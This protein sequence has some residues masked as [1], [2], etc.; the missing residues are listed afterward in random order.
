MV[1]V[2]T[3]RARNITRAIP[4]HEAKAAFMLNK[5]L[6]ALPNGESRGAGFRLF[7]QRVQSAGCGRFR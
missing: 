4:A 6:S 1:T 2:K 5:P 7:S 3:F